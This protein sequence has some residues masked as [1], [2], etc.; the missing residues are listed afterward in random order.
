MYQVHTEKFQGP[1]DV[2]LQLI[3][4]QKLD[5]TE[6]SLAQV[7]EQFL[8]HIKKLNPVEPNL[9]ADFLTVASK[10][11]VIKSKT[12][13]PALAEEL[14][15]ES[16]MDLT[17]QLLQLKKFKE[18]AKYIKKLEQK[19]RFSLVHNPAIGEITT[20]YPDP[21]VS[22]NRISAAMRSLALSLE[23]IVR[24]PKEIIKEVISIADKI[25]Q[26]QQFL[27]QKIEFK[28]SEAVQK[29][30]K[31]EIIVTFLALLELVKQRILS[32]EQEELFAEIVIKKNPNSQA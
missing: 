14:E 21:T 3:E 29:K 10:L 20:F 16:G 24:L 22:L 18:I 28:L 15:D 6:I 5:I 7:T 32:V 25:K 27:T 19:N 2:L 23:E 26:L 31:T 12:L 30:S 9:L 17:K 11:L 1:L 13:L 4:E 8:N